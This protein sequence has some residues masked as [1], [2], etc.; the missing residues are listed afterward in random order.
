VGSDCL[1]MFRGAGTDVNAEGSQASTIA[2]KM[3]GGEEER[4]AGKVPAPWRF[5]SITRRR[6][7]ALHGGPVRRAALVPCTAARSA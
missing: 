4:G 1:R 7:S 3:S 6:V 2:Q 5:Q